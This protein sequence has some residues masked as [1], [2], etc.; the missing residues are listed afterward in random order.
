MTRRG[1]TLVIAVPFLWLALF[2]LV[3]F[4]NVFTISMSGAIADSYGFLAGDDLYA[5]AYLNSVKI[6]AIA[7]LACLLIGYPMAY[8]IARAQPRYRG[9]LLMLVI[10]PFWTSFLIR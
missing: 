8:G 7:C 1:R 3:P 6:A 5:I 10:L 4:L 9:A 2:F